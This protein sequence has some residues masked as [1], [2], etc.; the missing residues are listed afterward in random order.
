MTEAQRAIHIARIKDPVQFLYTMAQS[1]ANFKATCSDPSLP[2]RR[3]GCVTQTIRDLAAYAAAG[4]AAAIEEFI[5]VQISRAQAEVLSRL[6]GMT[7][8]FLETHLP[9]V[10]TAPELER[11]T[12][13]FQLRVASALQNELFVRALHAMTN[14]GR[15]PPV[16]QEGGVGAH[17]RRRRGR[18]GQGAS[19]PQQPRGKSGRR[20]QDG[21]FRGSSTSGGERSSSRSS[22]RGG[23]RH[24]RH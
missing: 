20:R 7:D 3:F 9:L 17:R 1:A 12:A 13:A 19:Q 5:V 8:E 15:A 18:G 22:G 2:T 24:A 16:P 6:H 4:H 11:S 23:H 21:S 14:R 10:Y